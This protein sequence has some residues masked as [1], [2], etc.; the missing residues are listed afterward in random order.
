M[1]HIRVELDFLPVETPP[2]D[3]GG[4]K[5]QVQINVVIGPPRH[6]NEVGLEHPHMVEIARATQIAWGLIPEVQDAG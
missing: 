1:P 5:R 2:E 3:E 4:R 6:D